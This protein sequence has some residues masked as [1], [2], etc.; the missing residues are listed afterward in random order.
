MWKIINPL[1]IKQMWFKIHNREKNLYYKTGTFEPSISKALTSS[2]LE[3]I[4]TSKY[5]SKKLAIEDH[6]IS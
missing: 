6:I 2:K 5:Q 1:Q 3:Y 4:Y